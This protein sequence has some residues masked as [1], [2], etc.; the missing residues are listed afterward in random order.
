[1]LDKQTPPT[2][3]TKTGLLTQWKPRW[4]AGAIIACA[5]RKKNHPV[6]V[7]VRAHHFPRPLRSVS[8]GG[9]ASG[10]QT[11]RRARSPIRPPP[12]AVGTGSL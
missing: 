10:P 7:R 2:L 12:V 8:V 6:P 3:K 11:V 5:I 9:S 4:L 1:M